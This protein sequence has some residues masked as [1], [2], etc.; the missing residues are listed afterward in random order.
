M[1]TGTPNWYIAL[2]GIAESFR[3][4]TPPNI[5]HCIHCLQAIFTFKPPAAIEARTHLQLGTVL[6]NHTKNFD[7]AT[8]H[9]QNAV[10]IFCERCFHTYV[11]E[12][13]RQMHIFVS[14][15]HHI[16]FFVVENFP[17]G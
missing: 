17:T 13:L 9:L 5:K 2:L 16:L 4:A 3:T 11:H 7:L 1:A 10:S 6:L 15:T 12:I 8:A 14:H